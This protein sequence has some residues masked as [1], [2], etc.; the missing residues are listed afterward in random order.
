MWTRRGSEMPNWVTNKVR[1]PSHV[2]RALLNN[3]GRVDFGQIAPFLGP[4]TNSRMIIS[5]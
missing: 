5:P 1:A 3:E 4:N 2:I